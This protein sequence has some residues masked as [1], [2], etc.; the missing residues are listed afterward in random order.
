MYWGNSGPGDERT[1]SKFDLLACGSVCRLWREISRRHILRDLEVTFRSVPQKCD[2]ASEHGFC[3]D[4]RR[5]PSRSSQWTYWR[6]KS[7]GALFVLQSF[8]PLSFLAGF[9]SHMAVN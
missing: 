6:S 8:L 1:A 3:I 4:G 5:S 9:P 2:R 7:R